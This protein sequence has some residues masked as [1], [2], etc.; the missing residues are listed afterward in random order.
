MVSTDEDVVVAGS[1]VDDE[2]AR[3]VEVEVDD[4]VVEVDGDVEVVVVDDVVAGLVVVVVL[5]VSGV[6]VDVVTSVQ[7]FGRYKVLDVEWSMSPRSQ[8]PL[9]FLSKNPVTVSVWLS[10]VRFRNVTMRLSPPGWTENS[11]VMN[12]PQSAGP[13]L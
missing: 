1:V 10:V 9:P 5:D 6:V 3:V 2:L 13:G 8:M 7:T 4:G 12:T 11:A